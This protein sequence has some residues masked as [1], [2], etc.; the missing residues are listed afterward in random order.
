MFSHASVILFTIGLMVTRSLL[1]LVTAQPVCTLLECFLVIISLSLT[2]SLAVNRPLI[3]VF[4][5][6]RSNG[7]K[8]EMRRLSYVPILC[9]NVNITID[10]MLKTQATRNLLRHP[11]LQGLVPGCATRNKF[12]NHRLLCVNVNITIDTMLKFYANANA[13]FDAQSK[14]TLTEVR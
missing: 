9:I 1:I 12:L 4:E 10:T 7:S 11:D 13:H 2:L 6:N 3:C 5:N 14:S 8:T